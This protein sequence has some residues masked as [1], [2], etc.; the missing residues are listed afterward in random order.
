[1][2]SKAYWQMQMDPQV[3]RVAR[4]DTARSQSKMSGPDAATFT[5]FGLAC[6][7]GV[8]TLYTYVG[9]WAPHQDKN[10]RPKRTA[11]FVHVSEKPGSIPALREGSKGTR[12]TIDTTKANGEH[13]NYNLKDKRD[14][15]HL[16]RNGAIIVLT[17]ALMR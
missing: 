16:W 1:M 13:G 8:L 11:G 4:P 9:N 15:R 3:N 7:I 6:I 17:V 14:E 2:G 10:K 12:A 5:Y